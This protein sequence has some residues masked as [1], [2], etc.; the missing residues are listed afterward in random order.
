MQALSAAYHSANLTVEKVSSATFHI[1]LVV[2]ITA[3]SFQKVILTHNLPSWVLKL[4]L[5]SYRFSCDGVVFEYL[6]SWW[7]FQTETIILRVKMLH[8]TE[9][10]E[11]MWWKNIVLIQI[12]PT[13]CRIF[14]NHFPGKKGPYKQSGIS[15]YWFHCIF[16]KNVLLEIL[17]C[18]ES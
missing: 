14:F 8:W 7:L 17:W 16:Q 1:P 12:L 13:S 5:K 3:F 11:R 2:L 4:C 6:F 10:S 15:A 18:L 9:V